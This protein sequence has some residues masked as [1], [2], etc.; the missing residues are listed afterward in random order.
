MGTAESSSENISSSRSP[1]SM[2]PPNG[3]SSNMSSTRLELRAVLSAKIRQS[4]Y[5]S[6]VALDGSDYGIT[7]C[8]Y[9]I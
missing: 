1:S 9:I 2:S 8:E 5:D 7:V 3:S 4:Y 6:R